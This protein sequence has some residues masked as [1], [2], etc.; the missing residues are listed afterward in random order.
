[1]E[2]VM[3]GTR[4]TANEVRQMTEAGLSGSG[5]TDFSYITDEMVEADLALPDEAEAGYG[6]SRA[7]PDLVCR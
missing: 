7:V 3:D 5:V 1:V 6:E 2:V 4:L